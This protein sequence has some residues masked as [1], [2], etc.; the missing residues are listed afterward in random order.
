MK[1]NLQLLLFSLLFVFIIGTFTQV[2]GQT[3]YKYQVK[4]AAELYSGQLKQGEPQPPVFPKMWMINYPLNVYFATDADK[5]LNRDFNFEK[6]DKL[7]SYRIEKKVTDTVMFLYSDKE[8]DNKSGWHYN[9]TGNLRL[10][11]QLDRIDN[12]I[13]HDGGNEIYPFTVNLLMNPTAIFAFRPD[14]T[15]DKAYFLFFSYTPHDNFPKALLQQFPSEDGFAKLG[16]NPF[17]MKFPEPKVN[18]KLVFKAEAEYPAHLLRMKRSD[19][20]KMMLLVDRDGTVARAEIIEKARYTPFDVAAK[21][22]AMKSFFTPGI[23]AEGNKVPAWIPFNVE[24]DANSYS[25]K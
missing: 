7:G 24:F 4:V 6:I 12:F 10:G 9:F 22:A 1:R 16:F 14:S 20:V 8:S 17:D 11:R 5:L 25:Q 2:Y 23:D 15:S 19:T 18:P 21:D 13:Y 3:E